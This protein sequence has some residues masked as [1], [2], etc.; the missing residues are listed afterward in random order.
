M[1]F[2]STFLITFLALL[3]W[4]IIFDILLSIF[5]VSKRNKFLISVKQILKPFY[6]QIRKIPHKFWLF[7]LAP[8]YLFLIID[9]IHYLILSHLV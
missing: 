9:L 4:V 3:K 1:I 2:F 5:W 7:D 6:K 8:F